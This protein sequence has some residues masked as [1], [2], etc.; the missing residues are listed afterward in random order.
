MQ[1]I[2]RIFHT[3]DKWECYPAGFYE[4]RK[5]GMTKDDCENVYRDFLSNLSRFE[6]ALN[7]VVVEWKNSCE[8]Y[9]TNEKM[10]RIAWLGQASLCIETGIP[11]CFRSGYFLLNNNEREAADLLALKYLNKWL[12]V[13]RYEETDIEGAG[14]SAQANIY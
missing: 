5:E 7:R 8:H 13:N 2:K 9:L 14:V 6:V 4:N 3:W 1:K 11:S 10:N 12:K